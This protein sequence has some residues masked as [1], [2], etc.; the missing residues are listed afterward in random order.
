M[1]DAHT[2]A[3]R[4][5]WTTH[6]FPRGTEPRLR[7]PAETREY[8]PPFRVGRGTVYRVPLTRRGLIL[9]RWTSVMDE[10]EAP[11]LAMGGYELDATTEDVKGWTP[12]DEY[13]RWRAQEAL[14]SSIEELGDL[15]ELLAE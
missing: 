4:W 14:K 7:E 12:S 8:D 3:R 6:R 10:D 1:P 13:E 11:W 9:G 5:Y 2:I 15:E